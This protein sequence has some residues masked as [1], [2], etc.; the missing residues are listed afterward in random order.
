MKKVCGRWES[1]EKEMSVKLWMLRL[2]ASMEVGC[3]KC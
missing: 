3:W 2:K 1:E